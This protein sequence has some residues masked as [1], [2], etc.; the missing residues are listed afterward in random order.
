MRASP[1]AAVLIVLLALAGQAAATDEV[2]YAA[3]VKDAEAEVRSAPGTN[4]QVYA[5]NRLARGTIVQ[6]VEELPDG[7][8]KIRPPHGSFSFINTRFIDHIAGNN[9]AVVSH[10]DVHVPIFVGSA[11]KPNE[12]G[13]LQG[14]TLPRGA[15]VISL[16]GPTLIHEDDSWLRIEPPPGEYRYIREAVVR[17]VDGIPG[18]GDNTRALVAKASVGSSDRVAA[19]LQPPTP[20]PVAPAPAA[21]VASPS[22]L[23]QKAMKADN[24]KRYSEAIG[25][26]RQY[27]DA[28]QRLGPADPQQSMWVQR[29]NTLEQYLASL[30]PTAAPPAVPPPSA[31]NSP[32]SAPQA[33]APVVSPDGYPSSGPGLLYRSGRKIDDVIA[34]RLESSL[35]YPMLYVTARAGVDLESYVGHKVEL[36]GPA[37]YRGEL[38]GNYMTVVHVREVP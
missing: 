21:D 34:Y 3:E 37:V 17:K 2:R 13:N 16:G 22:V 38:R 28:V 27:L 9:W 30:R 5:T 12:R 23:L 11:L 25:L 4:D 18:S 26:Y 29:V 6:V 31:T 8:L 35:G 15:Q 36:F 10:P 33:A 20:G 1:A 14:C 32:R 24:E 7:W 19:D